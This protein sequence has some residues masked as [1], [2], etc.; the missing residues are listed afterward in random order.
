MLTSMP[1]NIDTNKQNY[2]VEDS[3][4]KVYNNQTFLQKVNI[5][6]ELNV[7]QPK[8]TQVW[9]YYE[10]EFDTNGKWNRVI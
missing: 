5:S 8:F 1:K 10:N 4:C 7:I 9:N 6:S 3:Q 2:R